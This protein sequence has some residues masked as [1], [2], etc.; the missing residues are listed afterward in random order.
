MPQAVITISEELKPSKPEFMQG[1][2]GKPIPT[3]AKFR[4]D[5]GKAWNYKWH[6]SGINLAPYFKVGKRLKIDYEESSFEGR[7]GKMITMKWINSAAAAGD[8]DVNTWD[9]DNF[10]GAHLFG[11]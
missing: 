7:D 6:G 3:N 11:K 10:D 5:S 1:Q 4:D 2:D 8:G 9:K